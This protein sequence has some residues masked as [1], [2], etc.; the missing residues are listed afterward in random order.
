MSL[1]QSSLAILAKGRRVG[2]NGRE[3]E[4]GLVVDEVLKGGSGFKCN[5]SYSSWRAGAA[6]CKQVCRLWRGGAL[7][8][9]PS[10]AYVL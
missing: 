8:Q 9:V 6:P 10:G 5:T 3:W 2:V 1:G 7:P 4:S